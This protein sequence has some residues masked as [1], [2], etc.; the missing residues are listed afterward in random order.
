M[1][2]RPRAVVLSLLGLLVVGVL[3]LVYSRE[4]FG[5]DILKNFFLQQLLLLSGLQPDR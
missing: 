3:L 5:V 2:V 1:R 4:L